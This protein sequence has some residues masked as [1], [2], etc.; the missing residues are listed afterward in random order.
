MDSESQD[1]KSR[2][3]A[4]AAYKLPLFLFAGWVVCEYS[5]VF[6]PDHFS[7]DLYDSI[8]FFTEDASSIFLAL[9][10][11][12][13]LPYSSIVLKGVSFSVVVVA[14]SVMLCNI[15][16]KIEILP[17]TSATGLSVVL[18][19]SMLQIFMIRF[20]FH[21]GDGEYCTPESGTIYLI[22]DKPHDFWG[23]LGLIKS[24]LG[25]GLSVYI[26]GNC[27]WFSRE[28]GVLV[29]TNDPDWYRGKQMINWGTATPE[30]IADLEAMK[31]QRWSIFNNCFT[32]FGAWRRKWS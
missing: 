31:G 23:L 32:V 4:G 22:I 8:Y 13:S 16:V 20:I 14:I 30:K 5:S 15:F 18:V 19:L 12:F 28:K 9:A 25:G 10:C 26:D 21:K 27:Y 7:D 3:R 6:V 11:Y 29:K 24:A 17:A 2:S 1:R